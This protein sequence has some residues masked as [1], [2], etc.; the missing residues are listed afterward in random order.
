MIGVD[1]NR[2]AVGD[3]QSIDIVGYQRIWRNTDTHNRQ[4]DLN[5][6]YSTGDRH[7]LAAA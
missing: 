3:I 6:I 5:L 1:S 2:A 7:R 4:I